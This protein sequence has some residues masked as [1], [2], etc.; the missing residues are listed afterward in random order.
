MLLPMPSNPYASGGG[1]SDFEHRV[2]TAYV[3]SALAGVPLPPFGECAT[4]I[5]VQA[6]HLGCLVDDIVL[7]VRSADGS[8]R[9]VYI[10]AKSAVSPRESDQQFTETI[11]RA[12]QQWNSSTKFDQSRD[13]F[14]LASAI[15]RSPRIYLFGRLTET[16]RATASSSD[17][18]HRLSLEGYQNAAV[19]ELCR[20]LT[21]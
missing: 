17:F 9:R 20:K 21:P 10:S 14:L 7:E 16:A 8:T 12:W 11:T 18:E 13:A 15:S 6:A 19:R 1:G 2:A 3:C 5:W 4:T